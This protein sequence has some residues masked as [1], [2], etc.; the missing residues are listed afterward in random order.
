MFKNK[1]ILAL[2]TIRKNTSQTF[3]NLIG[4]SLAFAIG[5]FAFQYIQDELSFDTHHKYA[6]D[7]YKVSSFRVYSNGSETNFASSPAALYTELLPDYPEIVAST[8]MHDLNELTVRKGETL[9]KEKDIFLADSTFFTVFE[10]PMVQGNPLTALKNP[11]SVVLTTEMAEKYFGNEN[12]MGKSVEIGNWLLT[13]TGIIEPAPSRSQMRYNFL[14][15]LTQERAPYDLSIWTAAFVYHTYVRMQPGV[16]IASLEER[17]AQVVPAKASPSRQNLTGET[18]EEFIAKGNILR[19]EFANIKDIHMGPF[20][21]GLLKPAGDTTTLTILGVIALAILVVS[22]IN[23][24][25]LSIA[26]ALPRA[27]DVGV[28]K[29]LG[30]NRGQLIQQFLLE[31]FILCAIAM[32]IGLILLSS[33]MPF[34]NEFVEKN[35]SLMEF[36][37]GTG[38]IITL[39]LLVILS[40][41]AGI[42]P[43]LL[44]SSFNPALVLKGVLGNLSGKS[45]LR[46]A[47]VTVQFAVSTLLI[48]STLTFYYQIGFMKSQNLGFNED[49][50]LSLKGVDAIDPGTFGTFKQQLKNNAQIRAVSGVSQEIGAGNL[51]GY[52]FYLAD[53]PAEETIVVQ[54]LFAD[55]EFLETLGVGIVEGRAFSPEFADSTR[56]LINQEAAKRFEWTD[57][58]VGKWAMNP[59]V[60]V[61]QDVI[62]VMN[63]FHF[64]PLDEAINPLFYLLNN[65]EQQYNNAYVRIAPEDVPGTLAYIETVWKQFAPNEPF[66]YSFTDQDL[67]LVYKS[68]EQSGT[69]LSFFAIIAILISGI[70]LFGLA[71]FV[72]EQRKKEIGIRKVLG[73][74]TW[75]ILI[76]LSRSF[77]AIITIALL[78]AIPSGWYMMNEWLNGFAYHIEL[79]ADVFIIAG[80]SVVLFA[81]FTISFRTIKMV[82]INPINSIKQ[83]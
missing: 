38:A 5:L 37:M 83:D 45:R 26:G 31:T 72:A 2:R 63:D 16:D 77:I 71:S 66:L 48:I 20:G 17:I 59:F 79:G 18:F 58:P 69:L 25:N 42:F 23:F 68:E 7:I 34:L 21:A 65:G 39:L 36:M 15:P 28:K 27:K 29:S 75:S 8:R 53:K 6:D 32:T 52:S 40:I 55:Y 12:P 74:D 50:L 54:T 76:L 44:V 11:N 43:A 4:L 24:V 19:F 9:L 41:G 30:A 33:I 49:Q 10:L 56:L 47:L 14:V 73:A 13:V 81:L 61:Q 51:T 70:G 1:L 80:I 62:G 78:L 60:K 67:D 22:G 35:L 57:D 64:Q 3:I 46:N 82:N